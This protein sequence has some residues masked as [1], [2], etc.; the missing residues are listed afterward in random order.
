MNATERRNKIEQL[1]KEKKEI[2]VSALNNMFNVSGVT[3]R[4]DLIFLERKGIAKR[5][6]G[7][8]ILK[9]DITLDHHLHDSKNIA[10]K[11]KIGKAAANLIKPGDSVL[12]YA[13]STTQQIIRYID[14]SISFI[15]VTNSILIAQELR[16]LPKAKI[17]LVG[18]N[19]SHAIGATYGLQAIKQIKEYNFDKLFLAVDGVDSKM[20]ITN[21][22]PFESDINRV[23]LER[24]NT[25][26]VVADNSKIG[27]VT[28][29][30]MGNIND[31]DI[32]I[33]DAKA[34]AVE[35]DKI[36]EKGVEVITT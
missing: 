19:F 16:S 31:V 1:L 28:F 9:N 20:G 27:N 12:F 5:L 7:K 17:V 33:T 36:R 11:E 14:T 13:G 4:N 29:V 26:I 25:V 34:S 15:A 8:I 18:G 30:Q 23:I 21:S 22:E 32:L 3:I 10:E 6:F 24:S 2:E 35:L